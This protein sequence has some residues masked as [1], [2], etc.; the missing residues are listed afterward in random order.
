MVKKSLVNT[1]LTASNV[2]C[3]SLFLTSSFIKEWRWLNL[4]GCH[5]Q[6]KGL[7]ILYHALCHN[8][9]VTFV[10]LG[11]NTNSLTSQSAPLIGEITVKCKVQDL[12]ITIQITLEI[13][14]S[15]TPC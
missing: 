2:E 4:S 6:D 12:M 7:N 14:S 9:D 5:I 13:T 15:S 10:L 11:L 1:T 3:I 8:T